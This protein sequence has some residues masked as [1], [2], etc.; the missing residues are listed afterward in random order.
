MA[1]IIDLLIGFFLGWGSCMLLDSFFWRNKR[2]CPEAEQRLNDAI[3]KLESDKK[4]LL[5]KIARLTE[6]AEGRD[7]EI[8]TQRNHD[9]ALNSDSSVFSPTDEITSADSDT[10]A[11]ENR[12]KQ[13]MDPRNVL[14]DPNSD[15]NPIGQAPQAATQV[16]GV[17]AMVSEPGNLFDSTP[18]E[19]T[20]DTRA[21]TTQE[22]A[23][24]AA[25]DASTEHCSQSTGILSPAYLNAT[26]SGVSVDDAV[27]ATRPSDDGLESCTRQSAVTLGESAV[28]SDSVVLDQLTTDTRVDLEIA[29]KAG[30]ED[31]ENRSAQQTYAAMSA[32]ER[33][34][35]AE[36]GSDN[37]TL[38]MNSEEPEP[39][40]S[41]T[42]RVSAD[43]LTRIWGIGR[44]KQ[45]AL[46]E[47]GIYT[48]RTLAETPVAELD[49]LVAKGGYRFN[50]ANQSTWTEQTQLAA[51]GRWEALRVLQ[52]K[53]KSRLLQE[54]GGFALHDNLKVIW[55]IGKLK[56]RALH[57]VGIYI[58]KQLATTPVS[59]FD[60]LVHQG[61]D[62]F[63]LANQATWQE[64]ARLAASEQWAALRAL[65]HRLKKK[66][67]AG[68]D[69]LRMLYGIGKQK[70]KALNQA[71]I[72]S[73]E[74]LAATPVAELD[75]LVARGRGYFNH[76]NQVTWPEQAWLAVNKQWGDLYFLQEK[77]RLERGP[78]SPTQLGTRGDN[79]R[80]IWGIGKR[81][82]KALSAAGIHTFAQLSSMAVSELDA[83][84]TQ[85]REGFNLA[86]QS[87]W[88]QQ[89]R[90]ATE[91]QWDALLNL[92][93][94]LKA[95]DRTQHDDLRVILGIGKKKQ[96]ALHR[97]GI[98]TLDQLATTPPSDFDALITQ[99]KYHFNLCNQATWSKQARL[100]V[101]RDWRALFAYQ[102]TLRE[103]AI[104]G[105]R[106][107]F[108]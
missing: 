8:A 19:T 69:D 84:V 40:K 57:R 83:M 32:S 13:G 78:E 104:G 56:Q 7:I 16:M 39:V 55:G 90:L 45:Q 53:L 101:G 14:G 41:E 73:F 105:S 92:Q 64:Q 95:E 3:N 20:P 80:L 37:N 93:K 22:L 30:E 67:E 33:L 77:L 58:F 27:Y 70:Q 38:A 18:G 4:Y 94:K 71:G 31:H 10:P 82:Q 61:R 63:N 75:S 21:F 49:D 98:Y 96:K 65:Q 108:V 34:S 12:I 62:E 91:Q 1:V 87:N 103:H 66:R 9:Q 36:Y 50:W 44:N 76:S 60:N 52:E 89:A 106:G 100:A 54:I 68:C 97:M 102:Q 85:G 42:E 79:L 74:Q 23:S 24:D 11:Q 6:T 43:E 72:F 29:Q 28:T 15:K 86:N 88:P 51:S 107:R 35:E 2:I 48:F 25:V 26:E 17:A 99:G 59:F 81:K 5:S 46:H 47:R